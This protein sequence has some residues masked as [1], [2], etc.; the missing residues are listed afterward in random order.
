MS[1]LLIGCGSDDSEQ[2][3]SG[4]E[5]VSTAIELNRFDTFVSTDSAYAIRKQ[6]VG[7]QSER[8]EKRFYQSDNNMTS[9]EEGSLIADD[10]EERILAFGNR[11][12]SN[13]ASADIK[14][15][16]TMLIFDMPDLM[17]GK[18]ER[19]SIQYTLFDLSGYTLAQ[20]RQSAID[21]KGITTVLSKFDA[22]PENT[23]FPEGSLC[24]VETYETASIPLFINFFTSFAIPSMDSLDEWE[25]R[26]VS[27]KGE[28]QSAVSSQV[29]SNNTISA[30]RLIYSNNTT[31]IST[32]RAPEGIIGLEGLYDV[33]YIPTEKQYFDNNIDPNQALVN[34]QNI[35]DIAA[36]FLEAQIVQYY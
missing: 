6:R 18:V 16:G 22:I 3:L 9:F 26:I 5:P 12:S 4:N 21:N 28:Y 24:F 2:T 32:I 34:C 8:T 33:K 29:G 31:N 7:S 14:S 17:S 20:S 36:D 11:F 1:A 15:E 10:P 23:A 30:R 27:E 25:N 35:N 19:Y 13:E